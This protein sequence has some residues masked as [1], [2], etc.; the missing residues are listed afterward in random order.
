MNLFESEND[1]SL[2][3]SCFYDETEDFGRLNTSE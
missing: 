1:L 3:T 2:F